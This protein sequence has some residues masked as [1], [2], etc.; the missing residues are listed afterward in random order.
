MAVASFSKIPKFKVGFRCKQIWLQQFK[1]RPN[2]CGMFDPLRSHIEAS[3]LLPVRAVF[4]AKGG[5]IENQAWGH[6]VMPD[7][8]VFLLRTVHLSLV[9]SSYFITTAREVMFLPVF[10]CLAFVT[11]TQK[12]NGF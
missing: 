6:N 4:A 5:P 2:I 9:F 11:I 3:M 10:I 7:L 1:P 12:V 8:F